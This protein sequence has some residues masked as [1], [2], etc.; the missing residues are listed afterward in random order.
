MKNKNRSSESRRLEKLALAALRQAVDGV[1][2]E[3]R[4]SGRPLALWQEGK[5]VMMPADKVPP[6][7]GGAQPRY[8][9]KGLR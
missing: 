7:R 2:E 3:H 8:P 5:V 9:E 6:R 1:V 4:R